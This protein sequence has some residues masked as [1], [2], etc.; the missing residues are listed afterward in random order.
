MFDNVLRI[1]VPLN[2]SNEQL[3]QGLD[4][5]EEAFSA[6]ASSSAA[7]VTSIS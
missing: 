4:I 2:V 5:L 6:V 3:E 7:E 1:L